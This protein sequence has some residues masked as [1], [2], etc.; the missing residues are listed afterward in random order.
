MDEFEHLGV[1]FFF[2]KV[3]SEQSGR[4]VRCRQHCGC[5]SAVVNRELIY[6]PTCPHLRLR[7]LCSDRLKVTVDTSDGNELLIGSRKGAS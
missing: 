7:A 2:F 5:W 4:L 6:R 3:T 1:I